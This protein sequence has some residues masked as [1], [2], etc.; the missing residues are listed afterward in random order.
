[1]TS[2]IRFEPSKHIQDNLKYCDIVIIR[3][4]ETL[5]ICRCVYTYRQNVAIETYLFYSIYSEVI[6]ECFIERPRDFQLHEDVSLM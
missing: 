6:H 1:M 3:Y 2:N 5:P 4:I